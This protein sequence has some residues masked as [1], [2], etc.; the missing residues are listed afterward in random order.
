MAE[1]KEE[2]I[3]KRLKEIAQEIRFGSL[4]IELKITEGRI[5]AGDIIQRKEKLG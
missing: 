2:L 5:M 4:I 1:D 3:L